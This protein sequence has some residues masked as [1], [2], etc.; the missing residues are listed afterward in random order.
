MFAEEWNRLLDGETVLPYFYALTGFLR[1][2]IDAGVHIRPEPEH[3]FRALNLVDHS[4]VKVVILGQDPY[5]GAGHANGLAFAVNA[6]IPIPGSLRNIFK[7]INDDIGP[8][9]HDRTL[10]TWARQ[11]VLLLNTVLTTRLGQPMSHR[12]KGWETFTDQII[13]AIDRRTTPIAFLLWGAAAQQKA[14]LVQNHL[15]LILKAAHPSP[16]SAYNGFFGCKHFSKANEFL[17]KTG[18]TSI[19]WGI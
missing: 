6:H 3:M 12:G 7:E 5:P 8:S 17:Q 14:V 18:Q 19:Q 10:T 13:R 4:R 9:D 15:H 16:L 2:E 11:G 1:Q